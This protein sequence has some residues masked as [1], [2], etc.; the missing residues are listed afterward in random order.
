MYWHF[1][2]Y[3]NNKVDG[4]VGTFIIWKLV[5]VSLPVSDFV[6]SYYRGCPETLPTN[7]NA[8]LWRNFYANHFLIEYKKIKCRF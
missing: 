8:E 2:R 1:K 6:I 7:D 3:L 5:T 4:A